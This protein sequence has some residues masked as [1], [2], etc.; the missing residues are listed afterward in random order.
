[1]LDRYIFCVG[2]HLSSVNITCLKFTLKKLIDRVA[3]PVG[4]GDFA[5]IRIRILNFSGSESGSGF[6]TRIPDPDP[7][8]LVEFLKALK[9]TRE[10]R[11]AP[12]KCGLSTTYASPFGEGL[13]IKGT[14]LCLKNGRIKMSIRAWLKHYFM[15]Q[16][17]NFYYLRFPFFKEGVD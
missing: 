5:W 12:S 8:H 10:L 2:V 13:S 7:R 9:K 6:N 3:D 4:S 16:Q 11:L 14:Y 17:R 15:M 1:M